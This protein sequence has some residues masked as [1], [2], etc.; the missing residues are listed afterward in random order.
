VFWGFVTACRP[1]ATSEFFGRGESLRS[2]CLVIDKY[3]NSAE[4]TSRFCLSIISKRVVIKFRLFR[5]WV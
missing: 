1:L 2:P 4:G 3:L 5:L